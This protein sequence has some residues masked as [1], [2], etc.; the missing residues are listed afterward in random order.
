LSDIDP[1]LTAAKGAAQGI[2]SA[3]QS[4]KELSSAVDDI[5]K[6]GVAELQAKQAFKQRQRVVTGD[7]TIMTA[8]AEWRRLKQIKEAEN[9][10]KD[11]LIERYGKEVAEKE[12]VEIQ[13]IKERQLKEVKEGKDEFG[14]DLAKLRLLKVW[15]FTIAFFMVTIYYIAKGHL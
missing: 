8:F 6:L 10:L 1:I 9:E 11:S 15:C 3:I 14:R 2:K 7:T 12:W 4:G 5:Q 13:A